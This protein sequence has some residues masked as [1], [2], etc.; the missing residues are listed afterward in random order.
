M[1]EYLCLLQMIVLPS[2]PSPARD[3][4]QVRTARILLLHLVPSEEP[5]RD[6]AMRGLSGAGG[7]GV[8]QAGRRAR[9][10]HA[11]DGRINDRSGA[12]FLK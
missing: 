10:R 4:P 12:W 8:G 2:V 5:V 1:A 7:P 6:M 3:L 11:V 9:H